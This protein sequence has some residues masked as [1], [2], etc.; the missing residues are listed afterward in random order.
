MVQNSILKLTTATFSRTGQ[1]I[2]GVEIAFDSD[3]ANPDYADNRI[4]FGSGG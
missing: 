1:R 3:F 2:K 4:G